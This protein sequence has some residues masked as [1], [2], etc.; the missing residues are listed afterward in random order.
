M[1]P[2]LLAAGDI[3][4][5]SRRTASLVAFAAAPRSYPRHPC[6]GAGGARPC[7]TLRK[8]SRTMNLTVPSDVPS[9]PPPPRA[10]S[11]VDLQHT[12][13]TLGVVLAVQAVALGA[14]LLV[15]G[16]VWGRIGTLDGKLESVQRDVGTVREDVAVLKR[17]VGAVREDA[18]VLKRDVG[19]TR[20]DVAVL[21]RDIAGMRESIIGAVHQDIAELKAALSRSR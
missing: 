11:V 10:A 21:K 3:E 20:E 18:A 4:A 14:V 13:V 9:V 15:A 7:S 5:V 16:I 2:A 19:T 6:A 17:D 1:D 8:P 12:P